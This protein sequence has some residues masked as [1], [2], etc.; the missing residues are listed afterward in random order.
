LFADVPKIGK[1]PQ[2]ATMADYQDMPVDEDN[3]MGGVH[4]NS[5]IP[6]KAFYEAATRI[7]GKSW[8]GAGQI[9]Y[10]TL[11]GGELVARA[12]FQQFADL[13]FKNAGDHQKEVAGAWEAVGITITGYKKEL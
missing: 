3:D 13:T 2:P 5:G 4:I 6:N 8:E 1:D 11:T 9:W 10:K 12:T 7:G